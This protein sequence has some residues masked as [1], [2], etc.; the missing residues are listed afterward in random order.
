MRKFILRHYDVDTGDFSTVERTFEEIIA[1]PYY[2]HASD[3][4]MALLT[5]LRSE[6]NLEP[7]PKN[8]IAENSHDGL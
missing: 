3:I 7:L 6:R 4:S 2:L 8:S 5:Y 1:N